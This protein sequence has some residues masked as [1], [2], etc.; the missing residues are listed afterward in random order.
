MA[1]NGK[2]RGRQ[3]QLAE[4]SLEVDTHRVSNAGGGVAEL[5]E[6]G[7]VITWK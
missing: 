5:R 4:L 1:P 7:S 2:G 3:S 6:D